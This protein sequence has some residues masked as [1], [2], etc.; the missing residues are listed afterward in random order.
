MKLEKGINF[1]GWLSQCP[2]TQEH[3]S[4]F[5][6]EADVKTAA[7]W[8]FDHIR[9]PFDCDLVQTENGEFKEE[10]FARLRQFVRWC[11]AE[12]IDVILDLHKACG[13]DF[14]DA[15]TAEGNTLFSSPR[16]QDLFVQLWSELSRQFADE[17]NA[18]FELLNEVVETEAA[19]PWNELIARTLAE[20]RKNAPHTPVIYGGIQWNSA[21]TIRL[22]EKTDDEN[23]LLTFHMYEPLIFT[24][25]KAYWV[26]GMDPHKDIAYPAN[27]DYY[28]QESVPLGYKGKDVADTKGNCPGRQIMEDMVENACRAAAE[29]GARV[30]CGEYGVI[31]RAPVQ[32]T[33]A[34]FAD[35]HSIFRTYGV[36]RAVWTYKEKDFGIAGSHYN[37]IR[38]KLISLMTQ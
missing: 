1:G 18:A 20:I 5:I 31:D 37:E 35:I 15:E 36:G 27:M 7:R 23:V 38:E 8:G 11:A 9:L 6:T 25:Q 29:K 13:Y 17:K 21:N 24:H 10:G 2:H 33:L 32:D 3:Y 28:R 34:W 26:P 30:Y 22:L 12:G 16:L 14:N 4:S 19:Q